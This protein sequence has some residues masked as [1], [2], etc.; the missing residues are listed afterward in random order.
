MGSITRPHYS[1]LCDCH[2]CTTKLI[3]TLI[4]KDHDWMRQH[5]SPKQL[6]YDFRLWSAKSAMLNGGIFLPTVFNPD[7]FSEPGMYRRT[8]PQALFPE[9]SWTFHSFPGFRPYRYT[10]SMPRAVGPRQA[11]KI[12]LIY[13]DGACSIDDKSTVK[14]GIGFSVCQP[15]RSLKGCVRHSLEREGPYGQVFPHTSERAELRAVIAALEW[16]YWYREGWEAIVIATNST[17]VVDGAT[18]CVKGWLDNDWWTADG[19]KVENRDLWKYLLQLLRLYGMHGCEVMLWRI[20]SMYNGRADQL[21][22]TA[23]ADG[24]VQ[25]KWKTFKD[26]QLKDSWFDI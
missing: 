23:I 3:T 2:E 15:G 11:I 10:L 18:N 19:F 21:A 6:P 8:T 9:Q 16:R 12:P 20:E 25:E 4:T 14:A 26:P 13:T 7:L 5:R 17:Y 24:L 1:D 22:K